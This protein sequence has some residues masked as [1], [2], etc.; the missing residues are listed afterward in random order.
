MAMIKEVS[1]GRICRSCKYSYHENNV[2]ETGMCII[3]RAAKTVFSTKSTKGQMG[4]VN[5]GTMLNKAKQLGAQS[6]Q[7]ERLRQKLEEK[8]LMKAEKEEAK[9]RAKR[10]RQKNK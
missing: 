8:R 3:C 5:A 4:R 1:G 6:D 7:R 10:Q 2:D 9:R